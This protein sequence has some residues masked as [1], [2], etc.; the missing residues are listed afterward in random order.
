MLRGLDMRDFLKYFIII[1]TATFVGFFSVYYVVKKLKNP[2]T[3]VTLELSIRGA[4][5]KGVHQAKLF[6]HSATEQFIGTT[7]PEGIYKGKF[8]VP[9][10]KVAFLE[11]RGAMY[12]IRKDILVPRASSYKVQMR[13]DP[14]E[15]SSGQMALLSKG[16]EELNSKLRQNMEPETADIGISL[17]NPSGIT[18]PRIKSAFASIES[19]V[20]RHKLM[21]AEMGLRRLQVRPIRQE[22]LF[23]FEFLG[24]NAKDQL[25][26]SVL[27]DVSH[28]FPAESSLYSYLSRSLKKSPE[29]WET[30]TGSL[31]VKSS[32]PHRLR[33]YIGGY[34][35]P[36]MQ[37]NGN[38]VVFS[39]RVPKGILPDVLLIAVTADDLPLVKSNINLTDLAHPL[40]WNLP[41][42]TLSKR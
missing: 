5:G 24:W 13:L 2:M 30:R 8:K 42:P 18:H 28:S 32:D 9:S 37:L 19:T 26:G 35:L 3:E 38:E 17:F 34:P 23:F 29:F 12:R 4:N 16:I 1:F 20:R 36:K 6:V 25:L 31:S 40:K 14:V 7:N 41:E 39:Y 11:A 10:G 27:I 15:A 21:L 33:A 22:S